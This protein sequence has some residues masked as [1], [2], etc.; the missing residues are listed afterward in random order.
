MN[1][2]RCFRV[3]AFAL[4]PLACDVAGRSTPSES[5]RDETWKDSPAIVFPTSATSERAQR[6]FLAGVGALHSF[7]YEVALEE[8]REAMR[9]EP[10]FAMAYWGE[11][12]THNHP[13]WGDPQETEA[14]REALSRLPESSPMTDRER[15]W[16]AAVRVL[17]GDGEKEERDRAYSKAMEVLFREDPE[18]PEAALFYALSLM[19][20][21]RPDDPAGL[22]T[23]LRA[24][25]IAE[26]VY[27]SHQDHP[28]AAHYVLHAYD[29]PVNAG[30]ALDA[31]ERYSEIA[32]DTPHA[33]H[34]ERSVAEIDPADVRSLTFAAFTHAQMAA[35]FAIETERWDSTDPITREPRAVPQDAQTPAGDLNPLA[36]Y[37]VL[38]E[39][40]AVFARGLA[41]AVAGS[42]EARE[43]AARLRTIRETSKAREPLVAGIVRGTE[44]QE[45]E[46][47]A[48][49]SATEGDLEKAVQLL[50]KATAMEAAIP[51][52]SGPPP[53]LK[54]SHELLGE[55]LLRAGRP[56]EA[57]KEFEES[58]RRHKERARS[59]LGLGRSGDS[60]AYRRFLEQW[61]GA[62]ETLPELEEA[63]KQTSSR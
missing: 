31:A 15:S 38:A 4:V 57:A 18:D 20:T 25:A 44:I 54:P 59:L 9:I 58:L 50:R 6:H 60:G 52:P 26:G 32:P 45:L 53:L 5:G 33:L 56:Q 7:W 61:S 48:L 23:R 36:A 22:E 39:I 2:I 24:G 42:A 43:S 62:D 8:F 28:G 16:L 17:Y 19:G 27:R 11:A 35:A 40:P 51:P 34:M 47:E 41:Q 63:R 13:I 30:K 3:L 1:S 46:I 55:I 29:D 37:A 49:A 10:E 12:M 14:A 21:V